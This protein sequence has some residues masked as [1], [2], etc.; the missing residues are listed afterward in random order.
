MNEYVY[1]VECFVWGFLVTL[2]VS[3]FVISLIKREKVKQVILT[4]VEEHKGKAG[5]P[6]MGGI[7]FLISISLVSLI[8][9]RDRSEERRVGKEC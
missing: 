4:Y 7:I 6:T 2:I 5:T 8:V 1:L 3:P 9:L